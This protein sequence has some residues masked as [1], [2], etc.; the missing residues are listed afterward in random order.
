MKEKYS[1]R[2][3][4]ALLV[5]MMLLGMAPVGIAAA[6]SA[7][8]MQWNVT[9][10]D[11]LR[12]NFYL[13]IPASTVADTQIEITVG[14][15]D[16]VTYDA[17]KLQKSKEGYYI[18][19]ANLAAAQM[20]DAII[21][22][23]I[24]NNRQVLKNTYTVAQY[25]NTVLQDSKMSRYHSLVR[26]ML[27]YGAKAQLY[28]DHN[29]DTLADSGIEFSEA[30]SVPAN[31]IEIG[32]TGKVE[33]ISFYGA[34]LLFQ[35]KIAVRFYFRISDSIE[36]YTFK[37][38]E[39]AYEAVSK[40]GL[41]YV[42]IDGITP[43]AYDED[44]S[45]GVSDGSTSQTIVYSPMHYITRM[46][47][48]EQASAEL[49]ALLKALYG[50]HL[51]AQDVAAM[52][53][54][55]EELGYSRITLGNL[56]IAN[57][58][59]DDNAV[60]TAL[61]AGG[62]HQT[63]L[64][65]DVSFGG[66]IDASSGIKIANT[67]AT[68]W[69]GIRIGVL[70]DGRLTANYTAINQEIFTITAS[71]AGV[72]SFADTFN[73]KVAVKIASN[74]SSKD[75]TLSLWI[76][77]VLVKRDVL[78][79]GLTAIGDYAGILTWNGASVTIG[80]P[81]DEPEE[82][83]PDENPTPEAL[84]YTL[85]TMRD[86]G[87]A[88]GTYTG[89]AVTTAEYADGL[90]NTCLNVDM[91]FGGSIDASS[92]IK[93][94][95]TAA[96]SWDGI[97]IGLL[98]DGKLAVNYT[99]TNLDFFTLTPEEAGVDTFTEIFNLKVA[100]KI[101]E[102]ASAGHKDVTV[103]MWINDKLVKRD[104]TLFGL[105]AIG[106]YAGVLTWNGASVA[107][108]TPEQT[109]EELGYSRFTLRDLGIA[110]GTYSSNAVNMSQYAGGLNNTYLDVDVSFDGSID[111][112]S[113]IKFAGTAPTSWD[114]I[115]IGL[116]AGD[117]L[118][119]NYTA[120]NLEIFTITAEKAGVDSFRETFNLK[121]AAKITES[122]SAGCKDITVSMWINDK[123]VLEERLVGGLA[124][125]GDCAGLLTWNGASITIATPRLEEVI[126]DYMN[127]PSQMG[128]KTWVGN[129]ITDVTEQGSTTVISAADTDNGYVASSDYTSYG[130]DYVMDFNVDR[131][132][133]ILQLTDT[134]IIDAAQ[135]RT[136]NRLGVGQKIAWATDT[137]YNNL[138]RYI[139]KAVND[140][141]PDLILLTG[142]LIYGEFDDNGTSMMALIHC[143][144]SLQIPWA[145]IFGNHENESNRG[146]LWQCKQLE[147]SPYCLFERRNE[148]GGNGNYSIG[149][150][151]NG[152]LER[153]I[154]MMDSNGCR[155][156]SA[157]NGTAVHKTAGF[158]YM[159]KQWYRSVGLQ[160]NAV[161]GK[162]IPSFLGFH[163]PTEEPL[164]GAIAAGYQSGAD[165][166]DIKY[167][168]GVDNTA[169]PGDSGYKGEMYNGVADAEL[170]PIMKEIGTDGTFMG[171]VHLISTSVMYEG[172]RWT[173]GLKTGTYDQSPAIVGGTLITLQSGSNTFTVE[174]TQTT[175]TQIALEYPARNY[176][177]PLVAEGN[178][179]PEDLG[180]TVITL[181][182]VG[183]GDG[184]YKTN[185]VTTKEYVSGL[186]NVCL[187][188]DVTLSYKAD[189][190]A[191]ASTGIK[192]ANKSPTSWD[193]I[194][195]GLVSGD[196]LT[197]NF[198][199]S[200]YE[201]FTLSP[202]EAGVN[203]F[204][205]PFN[206][207]FATKI[208]ESQTPGCKDVTIT[209]WVNNKLVMGELLIGGMSLIGNCVGLLTWNGAGVEVATPKTVM[210][211]AT[212]NAPSLSF[213]I[214]GGDDVMPIA[215]YYGPYLSSYSH[216][217][218]PQP[219]MINDKYYSAIQDCGVNLI[220]FS[221]TDYEYTP[222]SVM[223]MLALGEKYG[224]GHFVT[225]TAISKGGLPIVEVAT[226]IRNYSGSDSFCGVHIVDEPYL[227]GVIGDGTND[228]TDYAPVFEQL[229]ELGINAGSN[230]L[231]RWVFYSDA[232][233]QTYLDQF[234][235]TCPTPYLSF[236]YYV[237]DKKSNA[238]DY[239]YN[240]STFRQ[241]ASEADIP[242]WVFI[243]AG[244]QWNNT[245]ESITSTKPYYPDE[246]QFDW[247]VNTSLAYGAKGIQYFPIIQPFYFA[248][249]EN[250]T[251]D[252]QRNGMI[253]AWGEK[254][255]WFYYAKN[256]KSHIRA[257][258]EVLMNSVSKGVIVTGQQ[259]ENDNAKSNCLIEGTSWRELADING[260]T[261]TGCF[262]YQGKTAIYVVN[263]DM[264]QAQNVGLKFHN[265]YS[266]SVVK[267]GQKTRHTG[268]AIE[269]PM[270][271]GEGVLI[272]FE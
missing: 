137:M 114:G 11:D 2:I 82:P 51:A 204:T 252:L 243:Q 166:A 54:T 96:T 126:P 69:D 70:D 257:I 167:T 171:H 124:A 1:C 148:I 80:R 120:T 168:I 185:A 36:N 85:I 95:N 236:D 67:S 64:D 118:T 180:Y 201:A 99:A 57:G 108:A 10:A 111:A 37:V 208:V 225:D 21:V 133:R 267:N 105:S 40:D 162:T 92:G 229:K 226:R 186:H 221:T 205:E 41:Y 59:Y 5:L 188:V 79:S 246:G 138:F 110:D 272:V 31:E 25:A 45:V 55:P 216:N 117:K 258:D 143:M 75:V 56:G 9:L 66:S 100:V 209:M 3:L 157:V 215:G 266:F 150:A 47:N 244:S 98:A 210:P 49:K 42:Q 28:F 240:L 122:I 187:N 202:E 156:T 199:T 191:D 104:V 7:E 113:G 146:V 170:L 103:T 142:D 131:D 218:E 217:G 65:V 20:T 62:I 84:G 26:H 251:L 200:N 172:I 109:P 259:A 94:A 88:N 164:L 39:T 121:F 93:I 254:N 192:F 48:G 132:L 250:D 249:A 234:Q 128:G 174:Q 238:A 91:S 52:L 182:D 73:L 176:T 27:N 242:L 214:V 44:I 58:T 12:A 18:A 106:N 13:N 213:D 255:Q 232:D 22:S 264:E 74:A 77:D 183:I 53:V 193:G 206:L 153:V 207:K 269:L 29:T 147:E 38:N 134:Q 190:T 33:G 125:I 154:F 253:G 112:S 233:F 107:L 78:V 23:V 160:V 196:Q 76:N 241:R 63:Y 72:N 35:N 83:I 165:S 227:K 179:T 140:T 24:T 161:A 181:Q 197:V 101:E 263:Y 178:L 212:E 50:Y 189:G 119:V 4:A 17:I 211:M 159:Q 245:G 248:W 34:S 220:C 90:N 60:R 86:L 239:F 141:K 231:P 89:N 130:L 149:I 223:D 135:C 116:V 19:H 158:S 260:N 184:V 256:M 68:S 139:I 115:K 222:A 270:Q 262:N 163:I 145:P 198:T 175:A 97:R 261:L 6:E 81:V 169:K 8:V 32:T 155:G 30:I 127:P 15:E 177:L 102:S 268:S 271:A 152:N 224:I 230:L 151:K 219:A 46:Y 123:I 195:I 235:E 203:S 173:F 228:M 265:T 14:S 61:V 247:N 43:Q 144:D 71:E 87:I 16:A 237:F 194:K 136:E 129:Y